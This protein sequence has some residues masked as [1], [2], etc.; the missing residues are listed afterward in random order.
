MAERNKVKTLPT[1]EQI[2]ERRK[3]RMPTAR[4]RTRGKRWV[5]LTRDLLAGI[6]PPRV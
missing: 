6:K 1:D 5:K 4:E 2:L 3:R